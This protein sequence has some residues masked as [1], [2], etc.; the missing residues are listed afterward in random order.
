[1]GNYANTYASYQLLPVIIEGKLNS[2]LLCVLFFY[3][4]ALGIPFLVY[5][6]YY[7]QMNW[8]MQTGAMLINIGIICYLVNVLGSI[9]DNKIKYTSM[10]YGYCGLL[11]IYNYIFW[12]IVSA[13]FQQAAFA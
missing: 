11:A 7:F 3:F 5:G 4:C 13:K 6:F 2:N 8:I 12:I 1:M 9:C 10:V